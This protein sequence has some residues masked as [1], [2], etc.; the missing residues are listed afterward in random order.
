MNPRVKHVKPNPD[1]TI[2]LTF[3]NGE[4]KVFDVKLT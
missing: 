4:I 1:Y 2:T 3:D